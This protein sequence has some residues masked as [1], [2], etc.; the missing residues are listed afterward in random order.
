MA[1]ERQDVEGIAH[2]ARL[3]IAGDDIP[4]YASDLSQILALVEQMNQ[5][6]TAKVPP[7]AHPLETT[8]RLRPDRVTEPDQREL[9]QSVA[10]LVE[11]GLYLVPK[12]IEP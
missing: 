10:P 9:F 6:D 2:L 3:A 5:V 11:S 8:Q 1:L 7:L 12:V 4:R